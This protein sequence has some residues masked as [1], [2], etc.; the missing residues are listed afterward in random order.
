[1]E[2][3]SSLH[4]WFSSY[5]AELFPAR[6]CLQAL[7]PCGDDDSCTPA[8]GGGESGPALLFPVTVLCDVVKI[9]L[10]LLG[11]NYLV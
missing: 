8:L 9:L 10:L 11:L 6:H 1:M 3:F 7:T 5:R 4:L 2:S